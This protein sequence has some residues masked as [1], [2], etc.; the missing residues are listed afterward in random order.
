MR[1]TCNCALFESLKLVQILG[2]RYLIQLAE[3]SNIPFQLEVEA[4]GSSDGREVHHSP[5]PIDWVFIGAAEENVHS[6]FEKVY[7]KDIVSM[8]EMYQFLMI[9]L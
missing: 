9:N 2:Q 6:P 3:K 7:K 5:Y 8:L 4:S 1:T